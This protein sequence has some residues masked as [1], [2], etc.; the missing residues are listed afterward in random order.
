MTA[1]RA[2]LRPA[3]LVLLSEQDDHGYALMERLAEAGLGNLD[4]AGVYRALR[5]L[6][7]EGAV[8]SWWADAERGARRRLY[9]LTA[10]GEHH[11]RQSLAGLVDQRDTV[12]GLV[13]RARR[14]RLPAGGERLLHLA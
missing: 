1:P 9:A 3:I 5:A 7:A 2:L 13:D 12:A 6:E 4:P 8:R 11:L 10:K 14:S